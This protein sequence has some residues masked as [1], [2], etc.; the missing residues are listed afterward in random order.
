MGGASDRFAMLEGLAFEEGDV[1]HRIGA[2]VG[3]EVV[4]IDT[5]AARWL[6][7]MSL[8][9]RALIVE[10]PVR[11]SAIGGVRGRG[12]AAPQTIEGRGCFQGRFSCPFFVVDRST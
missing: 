1:A 10:A 2:L 3:G 5:A 7:R 11:L 4:R 6:A 9:Q 12:C 8:H